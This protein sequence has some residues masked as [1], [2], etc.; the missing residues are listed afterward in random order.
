MLTLAYCFDSN[1]VY[2]LPQKWVANTHTRFL[3]GFMDERMCVKR[4]FGAKV[5]GAELYIFIEIDWNWLD[6]NCVHYKMRIKFDRIERSEINYFSSK[7]TIQCMIPRHRWG[8]VAI[9]HIVWNCIEFLGVIART[10]I[11]LHFCLLTY[12]S[13]CTLCCRLFTFSPVEFSNRIAFCSFS[14]SSFF[15]FFFSLLCTR[16]TSHFSSSHKK[17]LF[18]RRRSFDAL[19]LSH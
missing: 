8:F 1:Q 4:I 16:D 11:R 14:F 3:R 13:H 9:S 15:F 7:W 10:M 17:V 12:S 6:C 2:F 19:R 5:C 18:I